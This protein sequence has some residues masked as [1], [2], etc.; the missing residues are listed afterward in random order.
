MAEVIAEREL[1]VTESGGGKRRA[2]VR[3]GKPVPDAAPGGDWCCSVQISG[4]GDGKIR[5]AHGQDSFQALQL[6]VK[7]IRSLLGSHR[8]REKIKVTWPADEE[9]ETT[10]PG[11]IPETTP[12]KA[13]RKPRAEAPSSE[14]DLARIEDEDKR[15]GDAAQPAPGAKAQEQAE[16]YDDKY[17]IEYEDYG[18]AYQ[19]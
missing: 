12:P 9:A 5:Q 1:E 4:L 10:P 18:D 7:M 11:A 19:D 6:A 8:K 16:L 17:E 3:I 2:V 13:P 14:A 15:P